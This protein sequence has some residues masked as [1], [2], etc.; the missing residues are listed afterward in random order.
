MQSEI[1]IKN[2]DKNKCE[3]FSIE[4]NFGFYS[5]QGLIPI[6]SIC[7]SPSLPFTFPKYSQGL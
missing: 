6:I 4:V 2:K 5:S 7:L 3:V 1:A